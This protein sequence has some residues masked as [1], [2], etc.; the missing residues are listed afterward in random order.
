MS[1]E[2]NAGIEEIE[3]R[4][5]MIRPDGCVL[6]RIRRE[7]RAENDGRSAGAWAGDPVRVSV[8][9]VRSLLSLENL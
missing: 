6:G 4:I 1:T 2:T 3:V 9:N 7:A 8:K 5:F